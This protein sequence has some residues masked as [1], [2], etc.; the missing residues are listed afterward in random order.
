MPELP[1]PWPDPWE[2]LTGL[3][4][5]R[6]DVEGLQRQGF[7]APEFRVDQGVRRGPYYKLRWRIN[8]RQ[9]VKYLGRS[10]AQ[11]EAVASAVA[12][13]QQPRVRE[14]HLARQMAEARRKLTQAKQTMAAALAAEGKYYHGYTSRRRTEGNAQTARMP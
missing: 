9:R 11:A 14:R 5:S 4:L 2:V 10:A 8:G 1:S 6:A 12:H 3:G 7:V 13:L